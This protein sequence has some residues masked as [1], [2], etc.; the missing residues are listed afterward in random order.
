MSPFSACTP[1]TAPS[2]ST[3]RPGPSAVSTSRPIMPPA[4]FREPG[5]RRPVQLDGGGDAGGLRH[6]HGGS[7]QS[8]DGAVLAGDREL[9]VRQEAGE[10]AAGP[11][12]SRNRN[13]ASTSSGSM[14]TPAPHA[15]Q[16]AFRERPFPTRPR[17]S[18]GPRPPA[19]T[20]G[21]PGPPMTTSSGCVLARPMSPGSPPWRPRLAPS[22]RPESCPPKRPNSSPISGTCR[23]CPLPLDSSAGHTVGL[24]GDRG[25]GARPH[26]EPRL[27]GRGL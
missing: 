3:A 26:A 9:L 27:P 20:S 15:R 22:A 19:P 1:A 25:S 21:N 17:W 2:P 16:T 24:V 23:L 13:R 10:E 5:A 8:D 11:P 4:K 18:A 12:G 7:H 6:S 14:L